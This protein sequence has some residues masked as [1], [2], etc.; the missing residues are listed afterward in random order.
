[1][2]SFCFCIL[3]SF[4]DMHKHS[5]NPIILIVII[6][7][8]LLVALLVLAGAVRCHQQRQERG[9]AANCFPSEWKVSKGLSFFLLSRCDI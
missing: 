9:K 7:I 4:S 6:V 1:M 8:I 5:S 2:F 3:F